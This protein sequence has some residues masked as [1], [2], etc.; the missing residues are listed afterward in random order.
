MALLAQKRSD[1]PFLVLSVNSD[2]R[3]IVLTLAPLVCF[4]TAS[5]WSL[6]VLTG[7]E[8]HSDIFNSVLIWGL[9]WLDTVPRIGWFRRTR[10]HCLLKILVWFC[11]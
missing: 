8:S 11:F 6:D 10:K 7:S 1:L 5:A 4:R 2:Q 9:F 3:D